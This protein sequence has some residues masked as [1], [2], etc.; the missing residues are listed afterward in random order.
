MDDGLSLARYTGGNCTSNLAPPADFGVAVP[1][2]RAGWHE[3]CN[4]AVAERVTLV[5]GICDDDVHCVEI[6]IATIT[7]SPRRTETTD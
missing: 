6:Q 5:W 2:A 4:F 1:R 7:L 3:D